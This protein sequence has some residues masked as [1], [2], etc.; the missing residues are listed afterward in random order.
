MKT[1]YYKDGKVKVPLPADLSDE[2][3]AAIETLKERVLASC[4]EQGVDERYANPVDFDYLRFLRARK[5]VQDDAFKMMM[6]QLVW[7]TANKPDLI[8]EEEVESENLKGKVYFQDYD[9]E[10]RLICWIRVRLHKASESDFTVL[11]KLCMYWMEQ[12][13]KHIRPDVPSTCVLFDMKG[14][15]LANMVRVFSNFSVFRT[16]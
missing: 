5:F 11:Q 1:K 9:Y 8:T 16:Y 10:G 3:K 13:F 12:G 4:E 2:H 15:G 6:A 7:R 14:F